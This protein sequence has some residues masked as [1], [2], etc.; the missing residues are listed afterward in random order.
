MCESATGGNFGFNPFGTFRRPDG[1]M[2]KGKDIFK[3]LVDPSK[4]GGI[5]EGKKPEEVKPVDYSA[6]Y[7][8]QEEAVSNVQNRKSTVKKSAKDR[9]TTTLLTSEEDSVAASGP[10]LYNST[11]N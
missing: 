2:R 7:Q 5:W 8:A 4:L 9:L 6:Y 3:N 1:K 11:S 10:K